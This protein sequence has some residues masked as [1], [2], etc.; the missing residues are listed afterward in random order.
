MQTF[1]PDN[2][3][4]LEF[5]FRDRSGVGAVSA[6]YSKADGEGTLVL[7]GDGYS[8]SE[9]TV[10]LTTNQDSNTIAPG[11]YHLQVLDATDAKGSLSY[12]K[13]DDVSEGKRQF[14]YEN[15]SDADFGDR[16]SYPKPENSTIASIPAFIHHGE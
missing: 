10:E 6:L 12:Y 16:S 9:V 1:S 11:E 3:I 4:R 5:T 15:D 7:Q 8:E 14:R 2:P 13:S